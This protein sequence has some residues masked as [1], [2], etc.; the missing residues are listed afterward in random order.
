MNTKRC[1]KCNEIKPIAE[2]YR[3]SQNSDGLESWCKECRRQASRERYRSTK[4]AVRGHRMSVY[5][6]GLKRCSACGEWKPTTEYYSKSDNWDNL[7]HK[8]KVCKS[9]TRHTQYL[10]H[11]E[12]R[13]REGRLAY[14][15]NRERKLALG[16]KWRRENRAA[17]RAIWHRYNA[18]RKSAPGS[19][20]G[21]Q[22]EALVSYYC[23]DGYCLCCGEKE[24]LHADHI[25]PL[26]KGGMNYITN[27]QPLCRSC[28]GGKCNRHS[29]DYRPDGGLFARRLLSESTHGT[30]C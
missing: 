19:F 2:F 20:T 4:E 29:T 28:N 11:R 3:S 10:K 6:D 16:R 18:R 8:C 30:T 17:S 1:T 9:V 13:L 27:I 22:W 5:R 23:P 21:K 12:K 24:P 25:V 7:S 15:R 14:R 26:S